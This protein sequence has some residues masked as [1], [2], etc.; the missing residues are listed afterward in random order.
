MSCTPIGDMGDPIGP[1]LNGST[2]IV[3]P[4]IEPSK[5]D[6]NLRRIANGSSQLLVG[7]AASFEREQMKVRFSTRATSLGCECA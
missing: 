3:R 1:M 5:S 2:Y 7:P 6:L 4:A